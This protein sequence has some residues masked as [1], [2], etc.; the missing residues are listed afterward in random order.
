MAGGGGGGGMVDG[1]PGSGGGGD[2][3]AKDGPFLPHTRTNFDVK[4]EFIGIVKV[5]NP[6]NRSLFFPEEDKVASS[7]NPAGAGN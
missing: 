5:Y 6:V 7:G 2:E 4:I 1:N 3:D